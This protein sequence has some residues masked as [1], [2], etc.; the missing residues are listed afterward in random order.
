MAFSSRLERSDTPQV[1]WLCLPADEE[2]LHRA[3]LRSGIADPAD[4]R[5]RLEDSVFSAAVEAVLDIQ[6]ESIFELNRLAQAVDRLL[7][8]QRMKLGAVV[9]MAEPVNVRQLR[10]LAEN[11]DQF[12]FAPG[13]RSPEE[14]GRY[15][16]RDSGYFSY[17]PNLEDF[18]D[19]EK[20]GLQQMAQEKGCFTEQGY[21][22]CQSEQ[23]LEEL[24]WEGMECQKPAE[25]EMQMGG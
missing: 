23:S 16:I 25:P 8:D 7:W 2:Q 6:N 9:A 19:F 1:T 3:L 17:D 20:Y 18:Y 22:S 21:L 5:F 4:F 11:L 14:Y 24:L 15:L 13:V 10:Q 12:E